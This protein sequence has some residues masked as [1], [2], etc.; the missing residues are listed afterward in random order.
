MPDRRQGDRRE[1]NMSTKSIKI[2]LLSAI[3]IIVIA[4]I[5]CISILVAFFSHNK[6]YKKGYDNGYSEGFSAGQEYV[7]EFDEE[8]I[9][10]NDVT[11]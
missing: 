6:G 1:S 3:Y 7:E 9:Y 10:N 4:A 11:L 8:E 2:P 5:I